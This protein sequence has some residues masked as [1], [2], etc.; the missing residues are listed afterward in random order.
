MRAIGHY[1]TIGALT[2]MLAGAVMAQA[3]QAPATAK[4]ANAVRAGAFFTERPTLLSL[5]FSWKISGDE[6]RN[7]SVAV[8]YRRV[9]ERVGHGRFSLAGSRAWPIRVRRWHAARAAA[10]TPAGAGQ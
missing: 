6:N 5:G 3:Q 7:A 4:P 10:P 8:R 9:G 2:L 1:L